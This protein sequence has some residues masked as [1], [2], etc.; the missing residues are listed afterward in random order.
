MKIIGQFPT[1]I[2]FPV[3]L[4]EL[5]ACSTIASFKINFSKKNARGTSTGEF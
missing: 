5:Q 2:H 1:S 4:L 3:S